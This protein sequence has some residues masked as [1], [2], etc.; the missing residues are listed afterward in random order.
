MGAGN[1]GR[2]LDPFIFVLI[3]LALLVG[4]GFFIIARDIYLMFAT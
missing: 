3:L 2:A 4:L 1:Q